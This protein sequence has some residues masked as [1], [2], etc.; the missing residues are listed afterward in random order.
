MPASKTI[1]V[2]KEHVSNKVDI[3]F[4]SKASNKASL[5]KKLYCVEKILQKTKFDGELYYLVKWTHFDESNNTWE[6]YSNL[7]TYVNWM[8]ED[9]EMKNKAENKTKKLLSSG[10]SHK[11]KEKL[12]KYALK[13]PHK[14]TTRKHR[15][16]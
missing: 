15:T 1:S 2:K 6:P 12:K 3:I 8:I 14:T 13:K 16:K 7:K 10:I 5:N 9:F 4:F 11:D